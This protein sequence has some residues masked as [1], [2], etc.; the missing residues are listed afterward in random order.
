MY[1]ITLKFYDNNGKSLHTN[2]RDLDLNE[3][4]NF[5]SYNCDPNFP[6]YQCMKFKP[7]VDLP[8]YSYFH[9]L[10]DENSEIFYIII[11]L[12]GQ[13]L[14]TEY[15]NLEIF[16]HKLLNVHD[17][18]IFKQERQNPIYHLYLPNQQTR[19]SNDIPTSIRLSSE[20]D[21]IKSFTPNVYVY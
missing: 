14:I 21:L 8:L 4:T 3:L 11:G 7:V 5:S 15:P 17:R 1:S 12:D 6:R 10:K 13:Y 16:L 9:E 2:V 19:L 18:L 20:L